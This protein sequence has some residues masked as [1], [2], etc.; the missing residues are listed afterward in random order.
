VQKANPESN[1][2][3]CFDAA[4]LL[5]AATLACKQQKSIIHQ[6]KNPLLWMAE[7]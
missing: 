7:I 2:E 3:W 5:S 4:K 6:P 1:A